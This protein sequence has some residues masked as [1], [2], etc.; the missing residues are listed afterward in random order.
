MSDKIFGFFNCDFLMLP[1]LTTSGRKKSDE[2]DYLKI[3]EESNFAILHYGNLSDEQAYLKII[4]ESNFAILHY[5][6]LNKECGF[7]KAKRDAIFIRV[8]QGGQEDLRK[9][10]GFNMPENNVYC[11]NVWNQQPLKNNPAGVIKELLN[12]TPDKAEQILSG[13]LDELNEKL[14]LLFS[15]PPSSDILCCWWMLCQAYFL[16]EDEDASKKADLLKDKNAWKLGLPDNKESAKKQVEKDIT[17]LCKA[18]GQE[19][20]AERLKM[21]SLSFIDLVYDGCDFEEYLT[22]LNKLLGE[23]FPTQGGLK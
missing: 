6:K 2:Q 16:Y 12:L 14:K 11:L 19:G 1:D 20:I 10:H 5:G 21:E 3:I 22:D 8:S 4:E 9:D 15:K 7:T 17:F 23:L 18:Q 13:N